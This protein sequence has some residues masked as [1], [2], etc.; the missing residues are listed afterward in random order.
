MTEVVATHE[1]ILVVGGG[2][3]F[4][5]QGSQFLRQYCSG[6]QAQ[7]DRGQVKSGLA[8]ANIAGKGTPLRGLFCDFF[9]IS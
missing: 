8:D 3:W 4:Q 2:L 6:D 7:G 9:S 5:R 1:T